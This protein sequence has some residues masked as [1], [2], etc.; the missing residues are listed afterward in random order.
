MS[1]FG[2]DRV[3]RR[4]QL[5][6]RKGCANIKVVVSIRDE[7]T[8]LNVLFANAGIGLGTPGMSV[9]WATKAAVRW[10]VRSLGGKLGPGGIRLNAVSPGPIATPFHS[11]LGLSQQDL[12]D[13]AAG[14][15][16]CHCTASAS[17]EIAKATLFLK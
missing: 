16:R 7:F 9:L 5:N 10:L 4:S 1:A 13:K 17:M 15:R 6:G 12:T 14:R 11:K 3:M 8:H 2:S